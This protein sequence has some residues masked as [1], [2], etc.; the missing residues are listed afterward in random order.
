MGK[1]GGRR[2]WCV[3]G[4]KETLCK[5]VK[6]AAAGSR[7]AMESS[8]RHGHLSSLSDA[9]EFLSELKLSGRALEGFRRLRLDVCEKH[10]ELCK[11]QQ[12]ME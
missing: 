3:P 6:P 2:W 5:Q 12:C 10:S 7:A 1:R 11:S 8:L 4:F 9:T